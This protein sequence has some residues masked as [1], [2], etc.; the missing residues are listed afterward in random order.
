MPGPMSAPAGAVSHP[1]GSETP[2]DKCQ[3]RGR[4]TGPGCRVRTGKTSSN[5]SK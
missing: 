2:H 3:E 5:R 4:C 1:R